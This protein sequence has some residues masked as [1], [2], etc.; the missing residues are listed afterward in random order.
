[1]PS[2]VEAFG[3]GELI[4]I[5]KCYLMIFED[6]L[7]S[8]C[9]LVILPINMIIILLVYE[10]QGVYRNHSLCLSVCLS[11]CS[12]V[13][14]CHLVQPVTFFPLDWQLGISSWYMSYIHLFS[15][16]LG[17]KNLWVKGTQ[18]CANRWPFQFSKRRLE[19][20]FSKSMLWYYHTFAQMCLL[21]GTVSQV[22]GK[23]RGPWASCNYFQLL[24]GHT[25][26]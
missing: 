24:K 2:L 5:S 3:S 17:I 4:I 26:S 15:T 20:F 18:V 16:K 1:M 23:P 9:Y 6:I 14:I 13:C 10:V 12:S 25:L 21:I 11:V 19:F 7:Y 22:P 8:P